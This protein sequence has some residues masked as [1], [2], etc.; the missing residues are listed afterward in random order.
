MGNDDAEGRADEATRLAMKLDTVLDALR[1]AME[2]YEREKARADKEKARADANEGYR[3]RFESRVNR[4]AK[5]SV[6]TNLFARPRY[7]LELYREL[8][9]G[10]ADVEEDDIELCTIESVLTNHPYNDLGILVRG[11]LIVLAEAQTSWS[12]NIVWR[13]CSYWC[14]TTENH[15][16]HTKMNVHKRAKVELPDVQAFVIYPGKGGPSEETISLRDAFFGGAPGRPDFTARILRGGD[17]KGIVSQYVG[18]CQVLD[19]QR[20]AHG[21]DDPGVWIGATIDACIERGYLA[22]YLKEHR[23]EVQKI[24]LSM[25]DPEV[26]AELERTSSEM[27]GAIAG[28]RYAGASDETIKEYL[29]KT[30]GIYPG[31]AQNL[32]DCEPDPNTI[33]LV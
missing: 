33:V 4:Q 26:V 21:D 6:F 17:P 28:M 32:L 20:K 25:Y 29:V 5:D 14:F 3:A 31:Y 30:F 7:R 23:M 11:K 27:E 9:P 8:F 2:K 18:F 22:E 12:D 19:E 1:D 15:L 24:M 16:T 13:L 10:D